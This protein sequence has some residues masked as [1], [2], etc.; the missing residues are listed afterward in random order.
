MDTVGGGARK[1]YDEYLT[2]PDEEAIVDFVKDHELCNRTHKHKA[3]KDC[4]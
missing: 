3:R 2:E 4:L 1:E